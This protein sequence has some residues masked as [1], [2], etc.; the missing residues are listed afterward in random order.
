MKKRE[1][2]TWYDLVGDEE[3]Y[4]LGILDNYQIKTDIT[5][6]GRQIVFWYCNRTHARSGGHVGIIARDLDGDQSGLTLAELVTSA[7]EHEV[8]HG[9]IQDS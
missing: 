2:L 4:E 9:T 3:L 6:S 8:K 7:I 1:T 5:A